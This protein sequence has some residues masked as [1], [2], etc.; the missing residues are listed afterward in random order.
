MVP[1]VRGERR[2]R[3]EEREE[4]E[5]DAWDPRERQTEEATAVDGVVH[6]ERNFQSMVSRNFS[7]FQWLTGKVN[8]YN[9]T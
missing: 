4:R 8:F 7:R 9:G 5:A 1:Q 3:R 6:R 2:R